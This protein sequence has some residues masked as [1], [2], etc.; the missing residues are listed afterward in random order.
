[1]DVRELYHYGFKSGDEEGLLYLTISENE[2]KFTTIMYIFKDEIYK[3]QI[4]RYVTYIIETISEQ[5]VLDNPYNL[6]NGAKL[7]YLKFKEKFPYI[8]S[9]L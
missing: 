6:N 9:V 5:E 7:N 4:N 3:V 8:K 1:M 2:D